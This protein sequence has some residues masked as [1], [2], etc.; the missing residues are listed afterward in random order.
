ME[1]LNYVVGDATNPRVPGIKIIVHSCNDLGAWGAGFVMALSEKW[2]EPEA[3]YRAWA[4]SFDIHNT[5]N[6]L[7]LGAFQV[8]KVEDDTFVVNIIGQEGLVSKENPVPFDAHDFMWAMW[9]V[10]TWMWRREFKNAS[11]HMPRVGCGLGGGKWEDLEPELKEL[12]SFKKIPVYV[13][14]LPER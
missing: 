7:P 3:R 6:R 11:I 5:K 2:P 8:V 9:Q 4:E 13:Y 10:S 14:D 1:F 12:S